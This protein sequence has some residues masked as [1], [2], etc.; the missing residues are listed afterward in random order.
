[1]CIGIS[2]GRKKIPYLPWIR[3]IL[4]VF[5]LP[6][7]VYPFKTSSADKFFQPDILFSVDALSIEQSGISQWIEL[8][9]PFLR[10]WAEGLDENFKSSLEMYE[11]MGLDED[12]FSFFS[13][14]LDGLDTLNEANSTGALS[15]SQVFLEMNLCAEKPMDLHCFINW[16]EAELAS[17]IRSPKAFKEILFDKWMNDTELRFTLD[18]QKLDS[19]NEVNSIDTVSIDNNFSFEINV[20]GNRTRIIGFSRNPFG[21]EF[22][23][24]ENFEQVSLLSQLD[25]YRQ[26]TIYLK[27]PEMMNG[28]HLVDQQEGTPFNSVIE[29][30]DE[31][32][33][34][35][36]FRDSSVSFQLMISC[37]H[38]SVASALGALL[39]GSLGMA[40]LG[41]MENP[42]A[43]AQLDLIHKVEINSN[44]NLVEVILE[45]TSEELGKVITAH[46]SS[47]APK[48]VPKLHTTGPKTLQGKQAPQ[49]QLPTL[50]DGIFSLSSLRGKVV[51]LDF[52][53]T[54]CRP[55]HTILPILDK[56]S[57][58]YT[59]SEFCLMSINQEEDKETISDF[60]T[61]YGLENIPVALDLDG[62][63]SEPY[64]VKGIPQT[65]II[66]QQGRVEKIWVGF[67]PFLENDLIAEIDQL[68]GR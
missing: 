2:M 35:A 61:R 51:V 29:G 62:K 66:N 36:R 21:R 26:I 32:A 7:L 11:A 57:T 9:Y 46:L 45:L 20:E 53:A 6:A 54:W 1:M 3:S 25:P 38:D 56:V 15:L 17:E 14:R 37:K 33:C 13:F 65:V 68:L 19:L 48:P 47:L 4:F 10:E 8:K 30:M 24:L 42:E 18:L 44:A 40:Q 23:N 28:N 5:L 39:Q 63:I 31:I 41:L 49:F 58:R 43:R 27:I 67:S 16:L 12:D 50:S 60:L 22:M 52:W 59:T 34:G 64:Q 55:C